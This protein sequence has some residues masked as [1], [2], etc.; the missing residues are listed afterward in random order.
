MPTGRKAKHLPPFARWALVLGL[1]ALGWLIALDVALGTEVPMVGT[2]AIA[3]LVTAT[4]GRP[5]TTGV[6]TGFAIAAGAVAGLW[7][8]NLG[9]ASWFASLVVI[10]TAG[11]I[12]IAAARATRSARLAVERSEFVGRLLG[13]T[14]EALASAPSYDAALKA[15]SEAVAPQLADWCSVGVPA[16]DGRIER[17][18]TAYDDPE[19]E[20]LDWR[21]REGIEARPGQRIW[22]EDVLR[23]AKPV[24][25]ELLAGPAPGW[26]LLEPIRAGSKAIGVLTLV[27]RA[28]R[29]AFTSD[30]IRLARAVADR[31]GVAILN[32]KLASE[33]AAIVE[34]LQRALQPPIL[35][36][37][38]GWSMAAMYRPA[39]EVMRAGGDFYDVFE[40]RRGWFV[41]LGDIEGHGA[42][43]AAL[44]S[45]VRYTVRTAAMIDG[46]V[47]QAFRILNRQLRARE[48]PKLCSIVCLTLGPDTEATVVS[49]GHPLPMLVSAGVPREVGLPGSLLG[50]LEEPQWS[51]VRFEVGYGDELAVYTDGVIE[52][53]RDGDRFGRER[54]A[55]LLAPAGGPADVVQRVGD[56]IESFAETVHDDA[57]MLILRRD[58]AASDRA[59]SAQVPQEIA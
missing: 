58:Q 28:D 50:A 49:A 44:T 55:S 22:M 2:Y 38:S 52:A 12:A 24:T 29:R 1:G 51:R 37:V 46:D 47:L 23:T 5:R 4:S 41:V 19:M 33:R 54:L 42:D 10:A 14:A 35:P 25:A 21:L 15:L 43:A 39:G 36:E 27:N 8:D 6:V 20:E 31:A 57:A 40:G 7:N 32:T 3:L 11:A 30:E 16:D 17:L 26:V 45:M 56:A 34:T 18:A 13:E 9:E 48:R 59:A 53:R